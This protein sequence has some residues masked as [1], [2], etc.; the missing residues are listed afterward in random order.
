M[1]IWVDMI[2]L[3]NSRKMGG[4]C[5]AGIQLGTTKW[6]RPVSD[7]PHGELY[8]S[9][10]TL[11][12]GRQIRLLD[13]V[14]IPL[15]APVPIPEQPENWHLAPGR[16]QHLGRADSSDIQAL[17]PILSLGRTLL[18]N[19]GDSVVSGTQQTSSLALVEPKTLSWRV[20]GRPGRSPQARA[21]FSLSGQPY[22]LA[23]TH[24]TWE[25]K[26]KGLG[27]GDHDERVV[28]LANG[29]VWFCISLGEA[30]HGRC[31]KLIA[32]IVSV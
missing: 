2:C 25:K 7:A 17:R 24:P 4:K 19:T 3:A 32:A 14:R 16:W 31:Y 23:V 1:A 20:K 28:N 30:F 22:D 12:V 5:V 27:L 6:I 18:G 10:C 29:G 21:L 26:I 8:G 11:D 13:L 15:A 9:H